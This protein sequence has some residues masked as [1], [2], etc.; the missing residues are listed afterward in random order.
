MHISED[1]LI[2]HYYG[3]MNPA[4]KARATSH[5]G[6]CPT[7][8]AAFSRLQRVLAAVDGVP[9]LELPEGYERTVWA[10]L[11]PG[12][13]AQ[14]RGWFSWLV[15]SPAR[16]AWAAAIVA[17]VGASFFAGQVS[18]RQAA[19]AQTAA[20]TDELREQI[21]LTDLGEHLDRSQM[22]LVDLVSAGEDVDMSVERERAENLV[23]DNRLY[24]QTASATGDAAVS[25]L[26][27]DLERILVELAASPDELSAADLE[28]VRQRIE[29][30]SLLF[31]VRV[32]SSS[33]REKQQQQIR[34]RAG[35]SS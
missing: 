22:M 16:L 13:A 12:L 11:E 23:A 9:A 5:L 28:G 3:E 33:V 17:L 35:Q 6:Q 26:L 4:A 8:H 24:R 20:T 1:D 25:E 7:C 30:K 18:Q 21:L 32:L 15:L 10:R 34:Q 2:L 27:E 29:A 31:K 14:R 19:P